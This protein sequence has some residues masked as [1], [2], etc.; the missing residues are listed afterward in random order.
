MLNI[1]HAVA[2]DVPLIVQFIRELAEYERAP[3][4]AVAAEADLVRDGFSSNPRFRVLIAEWERQPAGYAVFFHHY[5]T[6]RGQPTLF[7]EDLFVRPEFRGRGIGK[8]MLAHLA[9]L[10]VE[11]G[12][13]RFEWQVLDWNTAAIE[14]YKSLGAIVLEKWLAMR[15]TGEPLEKLAAQAG[16]KTSPE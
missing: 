1:R 7:L 9:R 12:C 5:S 6:W 13:G 14:F 10:A 16:L 4:Q 15:L 11:E 2:S 3:E 8:A